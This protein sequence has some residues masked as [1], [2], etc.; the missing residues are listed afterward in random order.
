MMFRLILNA[1]NTKGFA[2]NLVLSLIYSA[3]LFV[4][5]TLLL[6]PV[7]VL[8]LFVMGTCISCFEFSNLIMS[9]RAYQYILIQFV[10]TLLL[11]PLLAVV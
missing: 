7:L 8:G 5:Y 1:A 9:H 4:K 10:L 3:A 2:F 11:I 6:F